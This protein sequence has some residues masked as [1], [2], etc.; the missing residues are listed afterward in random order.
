MALLMARGTSVTTPFVSRYLRGTLMM[1]DRCSQRLFGEI[2]LT[3]EVRPVGRAEVRLAECAKSGFT[4][5]I[6]PQRNLRG[7]KAPEGVQLIG[8]MT[9]SEALDLV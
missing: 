2:G 3:G 1:P 6:L 8:V 7:L 9:V 4:T 5:V